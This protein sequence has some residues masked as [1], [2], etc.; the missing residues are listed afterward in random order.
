LLLAMLDAR[1]L[2]TSDFARPFLQEV[3]SFLTRLQGATKS[4]PQNQPARLQIGSRQ[5]AIKV[6]TPE[7]TRALQL[8][9]PHLLTILGAV[10]SRLGADAAAIETLLGAWKLD[11]NRLEAALNL[12]LAQIRAG[13]YQKAR[14]TVN[15]ARRLAPDEPKIAELAKVIRRAE[16]RLFALSKLP[17]SQQQSPAALMLRAELMI[18]T[19]ATPRACAYLRRVI[20]LDPQDRRARMILA[21]ELASAGQL[22]EALE[23]VA[24]ARAAFGAERGIADL[25]QRVRALYRRSPARHQ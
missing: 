16:E 6:D 5:L 7:M 14:R 1:L 23:V 4:W 18:I 22:P 9:Q 3:A 25:E 15:R 17:P 20:A 2:R 21:L 19:K 8:Y 12:A 11:P 24:R 13:D 10:Q